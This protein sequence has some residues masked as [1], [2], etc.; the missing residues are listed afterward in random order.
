M[1]LAVSHFILLT[2]IKGELYLL[3][4]YRLRSQRIAQYK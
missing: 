3:Y 2:D 4:L 1:I